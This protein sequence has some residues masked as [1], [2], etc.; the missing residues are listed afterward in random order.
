MAQRTLAAEQG[1]LAR[2]DGS[3]RFSQGGTTVLCSVT[4]PMEVKPRFEQLDKAYLDVIIKPVTGMPGTKEK[5]LEDYLRGALEAVILSTLHPR[6][7]IQVVVQVV[8]DD[9]SLLQVAVNG[10]VLALLDAGIT[11]Q[12]IV[13]CSSCGI[14]VAGRRQLVVDLTRTQEQETMATFTFA[15][16][17]GSRQPVMMTCLGGF[18]QD[19]FQAAMEV[20]REASEKVSQFLRST[21][22]KRFKKH[23]KKKNNRIV[24]KKK[25]ETLSYK[26]SQED[27]KK[28]RK[29]K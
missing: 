4:G 25:Y 17:A 6:T 3:A 8:E 28:K 14:V 24:V 9:G 23:L 13:S 10:A 29:K 19:E 15:F 16:S 12:S 21:L 5:L 2:A 20:T 26:L 11:M 7:C 22:E 18:T 27:K 1:M